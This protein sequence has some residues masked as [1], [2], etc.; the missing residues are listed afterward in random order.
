MVGQRTGPFATIAFLCSAIGLGLL[1]GTGPVGLFIAPMGVGL[2][3]VALVRSRV[4]G[5]WVWPLQPF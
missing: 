2:G 1:L 4:V 3:L 5:V